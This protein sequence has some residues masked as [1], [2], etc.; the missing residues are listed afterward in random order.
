MKNLNINK[1]SSGFTLV[2]FLAV[3]VAVGILTAMVARFAV[4]G[5]EGALADEDARLASKIVECIKDSRTGA[6]FAGLETEILIGTRCLDGLNSI[7]ADGDA[8]LN[9]YGGT[10]EIEA[11]EFN[12][13]DDLAVQVTSDGYSAGQCVAAGRNLINISP[14]VTIGGEEVKE[15]GDVDVGIAAITEACETEDTID[16]LYVVTR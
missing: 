14:V 7:N 1:K 4:S 2:E 15:Q 16:L 13:V 9:I 3:L 6:T 11:I 10:V 5:T 8:I 12:G